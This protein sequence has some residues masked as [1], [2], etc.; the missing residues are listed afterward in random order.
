MNSKAFYA[1]LMMLFF[2]AIP[3]FA[4][5]QQSG[6]D[7]QPPSADQIVSMMQSKLN[8]TQ[9]QVAAVLPIIEKYSTKR[10]GLRQSVEDETANRDNIRSQMKELRE[11]EKQELAQLLS[12]DQISQWEQMQK[13]GH[14]HAN[15]PEGGSNSG[16][17]EGNNSESS[18]SGG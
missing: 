6:N 18:Q 11:E 8:L 15:G 4:Q 13:N 2:I 1:G 16:E 14:H 9:D 5:D 10:D 12:S 3:A 17:G 7:R